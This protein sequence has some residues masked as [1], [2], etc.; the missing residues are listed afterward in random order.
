MS[1]FRRRAS[2]LSVSGREESLHKRVKGQVQRQMRRLWRKLHTNPP[3]AKHF[4]FCKPD[5]SRSVLPPRA[6]TGDES[7][8][9][10][11]SAHSGKGGIL[12]QPWT[13]MN[14]AF[15]AQAHDQ[16]TLVGGCR[17]DYNRLKTA[18]GNC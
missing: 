13:A 10:W 7:A 8:R 9:S 16:I 15:T 2:A 11:Q 5:G 14:A 4:A 17:V 18:K 6:Y 3:G 1:K 12:I